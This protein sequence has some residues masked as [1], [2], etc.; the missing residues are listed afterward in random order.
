MH[1]ALL[2]DSDVSNEKLSSHLSSIGNPVWHQPSLLINACSVGR[3][4]F[5]FQINV[6]QLSYSIIWIALLLGCGSML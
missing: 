6:E 1:T 5:V 3:D 2:S 4:L